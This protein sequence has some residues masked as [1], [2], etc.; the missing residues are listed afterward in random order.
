MTGAVPELDSRAARVDW[1]DAQAAAAARDAAGADRGRLAELAQWLAGTRGRH[2][3]EAPTR[4]RCLVLGGVSA[5]VAAL[6]ESVDVGTRAVVPADHPAD[7]RSADH[8]ADGGSAD[9]PADEGT[10]TRGLTDG[11]ALADDEVDA[12]AD[13]LVVAGAAAGATGANAAAV[14]VS[15]LTGTEPVALLPRGP[16]AVDTAAWVARAELLRDT[17][18]R[19]ADARA[20][21][22]ALL[23]RLGD[24]ALA[25]ATGLI[26]QAVV[27]RTP[28]VL[29]GVTA[30]VAALLVADLASG[31]A[32]WCQVA[33]VGADPVH[34]RA[35]AELD[36]SPLLHLAM[37]AGDG[38]AGLLSVPLLRAAVTGK[39]E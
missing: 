34:A 15:L 3:A 11:F 28:I 9:G 24:A 10:V 1:P 16:A 37:S 7:E 22:V 19:A 6:A 38:V 39:P 25:T 5:A 31:A 12:G 13:L 27:R 29:D 33:D 30:V 4:P 23:D 26:L 17:R 35:V 18:Q 14:V 36:R 32:Q 2:P 21:P 8:P 20:D